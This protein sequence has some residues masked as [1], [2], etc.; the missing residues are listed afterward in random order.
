MKEEIKEL[1]QQVRSLMIMNILLRLIGMKV[2]S[3]HR[4]G[5]EIYIIRTAQN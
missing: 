5:E 2:D 4:Y 1:N 3:I